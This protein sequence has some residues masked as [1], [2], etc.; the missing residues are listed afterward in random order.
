MSSPSKRKEK[1][2]VGAERCGS[3]SWDGTF[4]GAIE[5]VAAEF[6]VPFPQGVPV[7]FQATPHGNHVVDGTGNHHL[8]P[9]VSVL[10]NLGKVTL[11]GVA[12]AV[13]VYGDGGGYPDPADEAALVRRGRCPGAIWR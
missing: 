7:D 5:V 12:P 6:T 11:E 10:L 4:T 1:R 9:A 13:A 2:V 3:R 8:T